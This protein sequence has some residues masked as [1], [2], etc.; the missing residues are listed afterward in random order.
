MSK[1]SSENNAR[2]LAISAVRCDIINL[3]KQ[4]DVL[5]AAMQG[6]LKIT[7]DDGGSMDPIYLG[8]LLAEIE[9]E[10]NVAIAACES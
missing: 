8:N 6:I 4:R 7:D 3:R 2:L 5:L 10:A 1:A 9:H